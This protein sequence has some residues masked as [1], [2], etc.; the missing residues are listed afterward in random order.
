MHFA[1]DEAERLPIGAFDTLSSG[2]DRKTRFV[3]VRYRAPNLIEKWYGLPIAVAAYLVATVIFSRVDYGLVVAFF[4]VF[5]VLSV[6]NDNVER[7]HKRLWKEVFA[8]RGGLAHA[9][10]HGGEKCPECEKARKLV[11]EWDAAMRAKARAEAREPQRQ[12]LMTASNH[13]DPP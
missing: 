11:P 9:L 7:N 10:S 4:I 12:L 3:W 13:L 1:E 6:R 2:R 8:L 5:A